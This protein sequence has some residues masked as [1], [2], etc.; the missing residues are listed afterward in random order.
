M[1]AKNKNLIIIGAAVMLVLAVLIGFGSWAMAAGPATIFKTE[2]GEVVNVVDNDSETHAVVQ[3][4]SVSEGA[5]GEI[6]YG[7]IIERNGVK[8]RVFA[9]AEDGSFITEVVE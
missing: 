3:E 5:A 7:D 2:D 4:E 9:I 1:I 6:H 8:E